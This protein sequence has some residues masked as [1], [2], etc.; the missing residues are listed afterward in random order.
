RVM[1]GLLPPAAGRLTWDGAPIEDAE[2]HR[3]RAHY[4]GHADAIKPMLT[5]SENV[6]FWA[7]LRSPVDVR[8]RVAGALHS[9]AID[10]LAEVPG[11]FLSAG[12]KRRVNLARIVASPAEL[13]LLDEPTTALDRE[14]VARLDAIIADHRARGGMV[15]VSTHAD[16]G[17]AG[18][19]TLG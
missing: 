11:R 5:V 15:V 4:V 16:L 2:G 18:A 17:L 14:T 13:W 7:R 9:F 19:V 8:D 12:Q 10:G 1:A 6:A 3:A